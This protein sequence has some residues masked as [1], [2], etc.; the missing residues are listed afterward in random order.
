MTGRFQAIQWGAINTASILA[1][2]GGGWLSEHVSYQRTFLLVSAFPL[3][4]LTAT[5]LYVREARVRYDRQVVRETAR[6][7]RTAIGSRPLWV[8]AGFIFLWNFS[9]S[10]GVPFEFYLVDRL[11]FSKI[12]LG[13]LESLSS[14][15]AI[16]GA[17]IFGKLCQRLPMR[18]LLNLSIATGVVSTFAYWGLVGR[19][20][21]IA[22]TIGT[23]AISM[24]AALAT[25][26]LA[27]RS[28]PDKAE[29]TFF[30]ALMSIAN[31]GTAGSAFVGGRLYEWLGLKPLILVS[32]LTTAA[33]WLIVP[34]IRIDPA[35]VSPTQAGPT[36]SP[37]AGR[38]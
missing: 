36:E 31:L 25:Y 5:A 29:G 33:C 23:G 35:P 12:F 19:W 37:G 2:I 11:G 1:G 26:D 6:A 17:M 21:A 7:V 9:P 24:I 14:A 22:L 34:L 10:F 20:S 16:A 38:D 3:L 28:C 30:A 32:G 13:T 15:A 27:A 4:S 18:P 8:A